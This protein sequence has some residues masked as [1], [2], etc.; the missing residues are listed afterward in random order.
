MEQMSYGSR[1][2]TGR[3]AWLVLFLALVAGLVGMHGIG[4]TVAITE[5]VPVSAS[6]H[7]MSQHSHDAGL[8]VA[9]AMQVVIDGHEGDRGHHPTPGHGHGGPV[10]CE[11]GVLSAISFLSEH[12]DLVCPVV[13]SDPVL[14]VQSSTAVWVGSSGCDPLSR[15]AL[16]VWRI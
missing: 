16:Q 14:P 8:G 6:D 13:G 12:G 9:S 5:L 7:G 11:A 10:C 15:P 4:A 1:G 2:R 3:A